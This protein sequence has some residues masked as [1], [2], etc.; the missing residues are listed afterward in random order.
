MKKTMFIW[1]LAALFAGCG[2]PKVDFNAEIRPILNEQCVT[3]HGGVKTN[4]DLNLQFRELALLGGESGNPAIVPGDAGASGLILK[5]SHA[6][7]SDRMPKDG[8]PLTEAQIQK[9]RDW[10]DQGANWEMHWAYV[11]PIKSEP[12]VEDAWIRSPIDSF[13]LQTLRKN[14]LEPAADANCNVLARRV[15]IDLTG[16]PATYEQ[17]STLC[18]T[19]NYEALVDELLASPSFGERWAALWLDL[20]RYADSKGYEADRER[21]IWRYR[22]WLIDAFNKDLPFDQ[23]TIEQLAGDLLPS[24]TTQQLIATAFNRNSMTNEEGGTDDEEHRFASIVDRVSTTWEVFQGTT[25]G[26]VQ[27]HGHPYD[28]FVHED[29]YGSFALF[30]NT[31][32]WDQASEVPV[33]REFETAHQAKG[34]QL[35]DELIAVTKAIRDSVSSPAM[36]GVLAD[37]ELTLDD[38]QVVGKLLNTSKNEIRRIAAK[39]ISERSPHETAF[40][41]ARFADADQIVEGLRSE[42]NKLVGEINKLNPVITPIMQ[43]L[44]ASARRVTRLR[45]R[46]SFL[47]PLNVVEPAVP[48]V[49]PQLPTGEKAD[50][51][52]FAKWIV[53]DE[54]P[55]TARV[56]VNRFWEQLFGLGIVESSDDFGTI[57]IPPTH[58][59][60]LDW[61]AVRFNKDLGWSQKGILKEIVLSATY[62]QASIATPLKLERDS[63]NQLYSRGPRFRM[64]AEQ[65]RDQTLAVSGLLSPKQHGPSVMP[66]QPAG[67]WKNPYNGQQWILATGEDQYRRAIYTYWRRTNPYPAMAMFDAPSRE[68]C[69][70]RRIRTNTPLQALVTLNDPAF[71][72][73]AQALAANMQ[74]GKRT[75]N[76]QI[77]AGYRMALARDP[78]PQTLATLVELA[79]QT[80]LP[81]VA[82]TILNLDEYLTKE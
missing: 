6:N 27:C 68:F 29:F 34:R 15:S 4:A 81:I 60:L 22:D 51:L 48:R 53:S 77:V 16:L 24:P 72:E 25:M 12:P 45:E 30:N 18:E 80:T 7:P 52:A 3:C 14:G 61:L 8:A 70:S 11:V 9:L 35:L 78:D 41:Q 63:R 49:F 46:G 75:L 67:V 79:G 38:P 32:D 33:L 28:P 50:R 69:I 58:P 19:G 36:E 65:L 42:K 54:N 26:C 64:S 13:V 62:R 66:S 43:E 39:P 2:P 21:S 10:I 44:P 17:A 73:A 59:E 23:F 71:W 37:W 47:S 1:P 56:T 5:V 55:L 20:S 40:I 82:N 74:A 57:G 76:E 31:A